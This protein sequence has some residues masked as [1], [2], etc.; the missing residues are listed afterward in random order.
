MFVEEINAIVSRFGR[1][2]YHAGR[3]YNQYAET[4]NHLTSIR[5]SIRRQMQGSWDLAYSW[6]AS[7]PTCH[8]VAM[9]WQVLLAMVTTCL[10]W[11]WV[12][13][14]GTL[15]LCFGALLRAGELLS[16]TRAN[17]L[18][19]RDVDNSIQ[20]ALLAIMEP[21]TR[22]SG[23]R[24]QAAK[25]EVPDL[26][27]V[28]DMAFGGLPETSKLWRW[29]GQTLR[30]RFKDVLTALWL[31]TERVGSLKALDIGSLCAGGATWHLQVTENSECTRRKGR[32]LNHRVM[33]IYVQET[34]ALL[35]LKRVPDN[36]RQ[37]V[38]SIAALFPEVLRLSL[39]FQA[40]R[41]PFTMWR[42]LFNQE[43]WTEWS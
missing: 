6:M 7:E 33:E 3:P 24:H 10:L 23:A 16:A 4:I 25:L 35:Y 42:H 26:L 1:V 12:P 29:S 43:A 39:R 32:W 15:S 27:L 11:G 37:R 17:L 8:H 40:L 14:A 5:P 41:L 13:L 28:T 9:P 34:A 2:L 18:L 38:M 22:Q 30:Q 21:K 31:P 36:T 20:Y 19:P